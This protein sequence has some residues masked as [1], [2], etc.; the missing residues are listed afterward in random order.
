MAES[1]EVPTEVLNV[2]GTWS[3]FLHRMNLALHLLHELETRGVSSILESWCS[4]MEGY[5]WRKRRVKAELHCAENLCFQPKWSKCQV[6]VS[7]FLAE[8]ELRF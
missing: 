6:C 2:S 8:G 1:T 5:C 3:S 7:A 4:L